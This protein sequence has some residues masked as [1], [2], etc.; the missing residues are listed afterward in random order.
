MNPAQS[1]RERHEKYRE[2]GEPLTVNAR[3][4]RIGTIRYSG[5]G[6]QTTANF[7]IPKGPVADAIHWGSWADPVAAEMALVRAFQ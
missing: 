1:R 2:S 4:L 6:W 3:G 5:A 7:S